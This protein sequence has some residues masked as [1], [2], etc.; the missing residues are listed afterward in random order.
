MELKPSTVC[1]VEI[2]QNAELGLVATV[3]K[4]GPVECRSVCDEWASMNARSE[5]EDLRFH[6]GIQS[7]WTMNHPHSLCLRVIPIYVPVE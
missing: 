5:Y 4:A 1:S 3:R 7:A 6:E 2:K